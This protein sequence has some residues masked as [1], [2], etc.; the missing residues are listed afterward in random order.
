MT[1]HSD[2]GV[3]IGV[4]VVKSRSG[5]DVPKCVDDGDVEFLI[6]GDWVVDFGPGIKRD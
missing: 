5:H 3:E 4:I 6:D 1:R 2:Q